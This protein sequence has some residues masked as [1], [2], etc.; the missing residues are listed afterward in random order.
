[1]R[2]LRDG[3]DRLVLLLLVAVLVSRDRYHRWQRLVVPF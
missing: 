3:S 1:M 2:L